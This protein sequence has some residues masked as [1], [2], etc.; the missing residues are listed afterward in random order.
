MKSIPLIVP[1]GMDVELLAAGDIITIEGSWN[2]P[3]VWSR[4]WWMILLFGCAVGFR[5]CGN[6]PNPLTACSRRDLFSRR[7]LQTFQI[8]EA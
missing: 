1:P 3:R 8:T 6:S 2:R 7:Q 4:A 5:F